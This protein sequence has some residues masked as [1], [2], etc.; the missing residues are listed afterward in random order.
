MYTEPLADI[1]AQ[2][3]DLSAQLCGSC[4]NLH[5]LWPY[6]RLSRS[7]TG[8]EDKGS[9][10]ETNL[11]TMMVAGLR[12]ILIAGAA[13]TGLL[14]LVARA[15]SSRDLEIVVLDIC[16]TPLEL[17]RR[18]AQKWSLPIDTTRKDL[19][20]LEVRGRFDIVL[21]HG[22]LQFIPS[23]DRQDVLTR[24]R[25]ALRRDGRLL[26]LFNTSKPSAAEFGEQFH[27][28]YASSL[29]RD[30]KRSHI[31]IPNNE[32]DFH[33]RLVAHSRQRQLREGA[34]TT[35][36]DAKHL[37]GTA[38]FAISSCGQIN[39]NV[40]GTASDFVSRLSKRRFLAIAGPVMPS[41]NG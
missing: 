18:L 28:D 9:T 36:E 26:M 14:A 30:L 40:V 17:C 37:L 15:A 39:V 4:R 27:I 24:I 8:V 31:A 33:T 21:V 32:R 29:I 41:L 34:F 2:A 20:E 10:L 16:E 6:M 12:K 5:A 1:A 23:V 38:G 11:R 3:Y 7:S 19:R 13:D 25:H 35:P 22:T